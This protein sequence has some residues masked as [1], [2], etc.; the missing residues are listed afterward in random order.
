MDEKIL[1]KLVE[2]YEARLE[3]YH[4]FLEL[5]PRL[6]RSGFIAIFTIPLFF[7]ILLFSVEAKLVCLTCWI[8]SIILIA[9]YLITVEYIYY[10]YKDYFEDMETVMSEEEEIG[11]EEQEGEQDE[12]DI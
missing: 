10:H 4:R 11:E 12:T 2:E 5:Y 7:M 9:G 6:I 3:K 1:Q 8:I